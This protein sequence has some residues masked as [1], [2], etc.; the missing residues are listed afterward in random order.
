MLLTQEGTA[1]SEKIDGLIAQWVGA[2]GDGLTKEERDTFYYA[3]GV[4]SNNLKE[5]FPTK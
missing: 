3:L 2:G 4:I 5:V 1:L